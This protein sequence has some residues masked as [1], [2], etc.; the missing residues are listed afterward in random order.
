MVALIPGGL[1]AYQKA[2]ATTAQA[3]I[4]QA[5]T[6]DVELTGIANITV[7]VTN[8]YFFDDEGVLL[9][10]GPSTSPTPPSGMS[11]VYTAAVGITA[12][13]TA[14]AP[15]SATTLLAPL[16]PTAADNVSIAITGK[17]QFVTN[18]FA[19]IIAY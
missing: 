11:P 19:T 16:S 15:A 12:L 10:N 9:T 14:T 17:S 13:G 6:S 4:I 5:V 18:N 1:T 7:P 8:Y 2:S 3:Q